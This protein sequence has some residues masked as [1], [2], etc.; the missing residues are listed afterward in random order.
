MKLVLEQLIDSPEAYLIIQEA[1]AMLHREKERRLKFYEEIDEQ[2]K[3]EF[4]NGEIIVHSPVTKRHNHINGLVF[5]LMSAYVDARQLGF[6]GIEKVMVSLTR[7]DYEPDI[8]YF[9]PEKA[10]VFEDKQTLFPAPDL[11]VEVLSPS[12]ETRDRG[13]KFNDYAAHGIQEYWII[14]PEGSIIEQY[15]LEAQN[16]QL[17]I[18]ARDG[19]IQSEALAGFSIPIEAIF[20]ERENLKTLATLLTLS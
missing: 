13:V 2:Q 17:H 11:V 10:R 6:V 7:N 16:Y 9:Q 14:D 1:L 8:C 20:S 18:K 12:T 5:R 19:M 3:V 15:F 4:I